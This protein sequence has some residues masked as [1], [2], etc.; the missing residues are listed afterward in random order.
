[1]KLIY[2]LR[3]GYISKTSYEK[4]VGRPGLEPGTK[5]FKFACVSALFG[6]SHHPRTNCFVR[7]GAGRSWGAYR[8]GSSHPS[9]CTFSLTDLSI[10]LQRTWLRIALAFALGFPEFTR[11]FHKRLL[12]WVTISMS[13]LL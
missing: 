3:Y 11:F 9:L 5:G 2:R 7:E 1:M 13:P 12:V 4:V 8:I 10:C 6:L